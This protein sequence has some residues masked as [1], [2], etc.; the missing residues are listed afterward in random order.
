[1]AVTVREATAQPLYPP[2]EGHLLHL[3]VAALGLGQHAVVQHR[4][5][6]QI[7]VFKLF[8]FL[9]GSL[10]VSIQTMSVFFFLSGSPQPV[11]RFASLS[12]ETVAAGVLTCL[13]VYPLYLLVFTL[14]RMSRSKV[15]RT[16][17]YTTQAESG[18]KY[19]WVFLFA[20]VFVDVS[21]CL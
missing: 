12:G 13:L 3:V 14:F 20:C 16:A 19:F 10:C 9:A 6:H 7:Q 15:R 21:V 18:A 2:A 4:G 5:G 8:F 17:L 1:M 11:S